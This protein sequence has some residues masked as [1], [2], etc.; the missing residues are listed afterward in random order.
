MQCKCHINSLIKFI[1]PYTS[2]TEVKEIQLILLSIPP[3]ATKK[4]KRSLTSLIYIFLSHTGV[5]VCVKGWGWL[6]CNGV[7]DSGLGRAG[8]RAERCYRMNDGFWSI[9]SLWMNFWS[10]FTVFWPRADWLENALELK[11]NSCIQH[12]YTL[13]LKDSAAGVLMEHFFR[14]DV[15]AHNH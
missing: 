1:K 12:C 8:V 5:C 3:S 10:I 13:T 11:M 6:A 2:D 15:N 9:T 14:C 4:R 7:P